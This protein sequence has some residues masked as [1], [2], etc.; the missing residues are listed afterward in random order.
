MR[1]APSQMC[2]HCAHTYPAAWIERHKAECRPVAPVRRK[3][4]AR[5]PPRYKLWKLG[6]IMAKRKVTQRQLAADTGLCYTTICRFLSG[7]TERASTA[8]KIAFA[9]GVGLSAIE[10]TP[11]KPGRW[12]R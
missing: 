8:R 6:Q 11:Y 5:T 1:P 7:L 12:N 2:P 4:E 3:G 9:L 10:T